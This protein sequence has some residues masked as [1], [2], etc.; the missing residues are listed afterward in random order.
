MTTMEVIQNSSDLDA[1]WPPEMLLDAIGFR[2]RVLGRIEDYLRDREVESLSLRE[3]MDLFLPPSSEE[4]AD[5]TDFWRSV[6]MLRQPQF[7]PY[8]HDSGLLT[9]TEAN[10]APAFQTEWALRICRLKLY[11]LRE[12]PANKSVQQKGRAARL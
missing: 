8:L 11:E 7:G 1:P 12:R 2:A 6:P 4:V 3:L 5:I 10:M 9:L